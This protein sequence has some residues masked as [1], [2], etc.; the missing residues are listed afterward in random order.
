MSEIKIPAEKIRLF[1]AH[2]NN[3]IGDK[4]YYKTGKRY[5]IIDNQ[6]KA[7]ELS[8]CIKKYKLLD[9][10]VKKNL[11]FF[12]ELRNIIE[13]RHI[14]KETLGTQIFGEC[15]ALLYNYEDVLTELFGEGYAINENLAFSLQLS[16]ILTKE[17]KEAQKNLL[18]S[19]AQD[20]VNYINNYRTSLTVDVFNSQ[21]YSVKLIQIPKVR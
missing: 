19:E 7:W 9:E 21:E 18:S 16:K 2:F 20:I 3:T 4:Y 11:D 12:V 5:K 1:H 8:E 6:R 13:H 10:P 17:Q 15:Q 14:E